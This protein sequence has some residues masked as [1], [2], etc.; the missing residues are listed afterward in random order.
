MMKGISKYLLLLPLLVACK[1]GVFGGDEAPII[2]KVLEMK[3]ILILTSSAGNGHNS[4][5]KRIQE[6]FLNHLPQ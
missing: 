6:K 2:N 5:A 4:A 3:K 1:G